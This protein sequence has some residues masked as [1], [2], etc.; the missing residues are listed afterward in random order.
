MDT[1][2]TT[3]S[4]ATDATVLTPAER[5]YLRRELDV[6][7]STLPTVAEGFLIRTWQGG[8]HKGKPKVP[9]A[10][11][12]LLDRG[13]ARLDDTGRLPRLY[14]TPAGIAALRN[15]MTDRRLA[16]PRKFAHIRQEL[17]IDPAPAGTT[18]D[19]GTTSE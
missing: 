18:S 15:M 14:L 19:A 7:F 13:L 17:G 6:F 9:A 1:M 10:A 3:P 5:E 12:G 11:Q 4:S 16:D 2:P 8:P